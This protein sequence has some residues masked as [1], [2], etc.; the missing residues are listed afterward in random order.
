MLQSSS[1]AKSQVTVSLGLRLL[2]YAL[3][4]LCITSK[5]SQEKTR[6]TDNGTTHATL[7]V[8]LLFKAPNLQKQ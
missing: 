2:V 7:S 4:L 5:K 6:R 3:L 1:E 8:V